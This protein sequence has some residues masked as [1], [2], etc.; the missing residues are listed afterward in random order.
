MTTAMN[1]TLLDRASRGDQAAF[2]ELTD[3]LRGELEFHCYRMLGSLHDAEDALQETLLAAWRGLGGFERRS[4]LRTWLYRIATNRCMNALRDSSRRP[5]RSPTAPFPI[6]EPTRRSDPAWLEPYPEDRLDWL[7]DN[8]PGPAVRYET[9]EAVEIT[10]IAALQRLSGRQRAVL[11]LR[12][13]LGFHADETAAL[14]DTS[15]DAV[16]SALK[17]ARVTLADELPE[18]LN[19]PAPQSSEERALLAHFAEA[20]LADDIDAIVAL[21]TEHAW[22]RM[23][24]ADIEYQGPPK[25]GAMLR[26][27][28]E[29]R[30]GPSTRLLATRANGQ[31]GFGTY[32]IDP[33]TGLAQPVGLLL[34]TL[35]GRRIAALTWF[36]GPGPL[37]AVGMPTDPSDR[38]LVS[39]AL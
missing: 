37:K 20:F 9:R 10:F 29:F 16:K 39:E 1:T 15:V 7:A 25:I 14:L 18:E 35:T 8:T 21:V 3:P 6:P 4:S 11:V 38:R 31:P 5:P 24:P 22:F 30:A 33:A 12:D 2:A 32:R 13:V 36:I 17:R 23:P 19:P 28:M 26:A 27:I 34:L